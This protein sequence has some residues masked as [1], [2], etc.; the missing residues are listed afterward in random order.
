M[1]DDP[2]AKRTGPA[3][4]HSSGHLASDDA[5]LHVAPPLDLRAPSPSDDP[6]T[7]PESE[8]ITHRPQV[9]EP[10][11]EVA[12]ALPIPDEER[13]SARPPADLD[14][15]LD[16]NLEDRPP[17]TLDYAHPRPS[18]PGRS[19]APISDAA[20]WRAS[21]E[22][23]S[24]ESDREALLRDLV[25]IGALDESPD[26]VVDREVTARAT[27]ARARALRFRLMLQDVWPP[28]AWPQA[29]P[30]SARPLHIDLALDVALV[31]ALADGAPTPMGSPVASY[32]MPFVRPLIEFL[33]AQRP[34]LPRTAL[35]DRGS[36]TIARLTI[37]GWRGALEH[38]TKIG[39]SLPEAPRRTALEL[40][41][42][43]A[44]VPALNDHRF[45]ALADLERALALPTGSVARAL[46]D[47]RTAI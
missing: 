12:F 34:D 1:P 11:V 29:A 31:A 5:P 32:A 24:V 4:R 22:P 23:H 2:H 26:R 15:N 39:R 41:A 10:E 6:D 33:R 46:D 37:Q 36:S 17:M 42:R 27:L 9:R 14:A 20:H 44:L 25:A 40:A 3:P 19:S 45:A 8:P 28:S 38:V 18:D 43:L 47:A 35:R 13:S 21:G 30:A 16:A 7:T